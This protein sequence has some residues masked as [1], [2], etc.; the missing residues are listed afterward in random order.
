MIFFSLALLVLKGLEEV[1]KSS[2]PSCSSLLLVK[3]ISVERMDSAFL[4]LLLAVF[5]GV[6]CLLSALIFSKVMPKTSFPVQIWL[7]SE[8]SSAL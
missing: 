6:N 1:N 5:S 8:S 3:L 7:Q 4:F 2:S